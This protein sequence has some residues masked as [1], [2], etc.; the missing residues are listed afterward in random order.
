MT[1]EV[2]GLKETGTFKEVPRA[3]AKNVLKCKWVFKTKRRPDGTPLYKSRLVVKGYAQKQRVDY[4]D[5]YAPTTKQVTGRLLLHLAAVQG[6]HVQVMDVDQAFCHGD[7][8]ENIYMEPPPGLHSEGKGD[9]VWKLCRLLYG[10]KQAP[11]QWH[12]K[13]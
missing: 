5:T 3:E 2:T 6:F 13:L 7:L 8:E 12:A 1:K 11:R 10:L 4:F 9:T